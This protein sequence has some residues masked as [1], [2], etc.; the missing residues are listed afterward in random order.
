MEQQIFSM[1]LNPEVVWLSHLK[2]IKPTYMKTL[3]SNP[4]YL[5]NFKTDVFIIIIIIY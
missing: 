2:I 1:I 5:L 4:L 3:D